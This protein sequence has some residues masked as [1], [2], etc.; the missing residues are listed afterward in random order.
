MKNCCFLKNTYLVMHVTLEKELPPS[1][2]T[3][4]VNCK[5]DTLGPISSDEMCYPLYKV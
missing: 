1:Q 2:Q 4:L 5:P 3:Q